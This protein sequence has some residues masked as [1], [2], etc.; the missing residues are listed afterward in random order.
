MKQEENKVM[1]AQLELRQLIDMRLQENEFEM[2]SY[3]SE[4]DKVF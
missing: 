2:T 4:N 1:G 3:H